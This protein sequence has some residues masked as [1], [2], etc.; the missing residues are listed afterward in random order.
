MAEHQLPSAAQQRQ[1]RSS[2]NLVYA[3]PIC[4]YIYIYKSTLPFSKY[5]ATQK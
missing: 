3:E 2:W 4:V 5:V 1:L